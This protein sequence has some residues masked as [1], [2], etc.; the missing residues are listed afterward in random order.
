MRNN[1]ND[2][3]R[4][5]AKE[6][7]KDMNFIFAPIVMLDKYRTELMEVLEGAFLTHCQQTVINLLKNEIDHLRKA[8][9]RKE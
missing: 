4:E 5:Q 2:A 3:I 6:F 8:H 1:A 9:E 7:M